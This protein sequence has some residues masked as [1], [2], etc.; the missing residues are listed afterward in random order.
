MQRSENCWNW[1]P[2]ASLSGKVDYDDLDMLNIRM[3]PT[4]YNDVVE[5]IVEWRSKT[6][7]DVMGL[8]QREYEQYGLF[9]E[10]AQSRKKNREGKPNRQSILT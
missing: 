7:E 3:F 10:Y 6:Q 4:G 9:Q 2:S 1:N 5:W 8:C